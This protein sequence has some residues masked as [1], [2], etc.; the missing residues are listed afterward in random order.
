MKRLRAKLYWKG[1]ERG[2]KYFHTESKKGFYVLFMELTETFR[3]VPSRCWDVLAMCPFSIHHR[4]RPFRM[5]FW[6]SS[7]VMVVNHTF[8][9][10]MFPISME[11]GP[12]LWLALQMFC[13]WMIWSAIHFCRTGMGWFHTF[14]IFHCIC[15]NCVF[16]RTRLS[17]DV[18]FKPLV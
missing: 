5:P 14:C 17:P 11:V 6:R 4:Q 2:R 8:L 13:I 1:S 18:R 9:V 16:I 3:L 10:S 15:E 12:N 7:S